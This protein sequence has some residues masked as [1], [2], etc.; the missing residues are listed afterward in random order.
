MS[1]TRPH[2]R[3][4]PDSLEEDLRLI[5]WPIVKRLPRYARLAWAL[6]REPAIPSR[7]KAGLYG[8]VVYTI[9]PL[10]LIG[11]LIPVVGQIDSIV[12]L[13]LGLRRALRHCPAEVAQ[14][15]LTRLG[16]EPRLLSRDLHVTVYIGLRAFG[17]VARPIGRAVETAAELAYGAGHRMVDR[18]AMRPSPRT[19]RATRQRL[20]PSPRKGG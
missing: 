13:L 20:H 16:L 9:T 18:A 14:R 12:L 19:T 5:A 10:H 6:A 1:R 15:H 2:R 7:Y 8:A 11:G 3:R 4:R 17:R